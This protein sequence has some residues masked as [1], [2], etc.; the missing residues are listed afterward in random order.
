METFR[1]SPAGDALLMAVALH[2][3]IQQARDGP[4]AGV[5]G[6]GGDGWLAKRGECDS[7]WINLPSRRVWR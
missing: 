5:A 3:V 1:S 6:G 7:A 4:G 2:V